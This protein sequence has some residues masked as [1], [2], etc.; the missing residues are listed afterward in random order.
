[1]RRSL[2]ALAMI[3]GCGARTGLVVEPDVCPDPIAPP[4]DFVLIGDRIAVRDSAGLAS[5]A[6]DGSD[7]RLLARAH[8]FRANLAT[9]GNE[10]YWADEIDTKCTVH[11]TTLTGVTRDVR[12]LDCTD[13][14]T[15]VASPVSFIAVDEREVWLIVGGCS[16]FCRSS[17]RRVEHADKRAPTTWRRAPLEVAD[18]WVL[19]AL[20]GDQAFFL[21]DGTRSLVSLDPSTDI[22]RTVRDPFFEGRLRDLGPAFLGANEKLYLREFVVH[23]DVRY[24]AI[25]ERTTT[26]QFSRE[27]T[28]ATLL[29]S[30]AYDFFAT[31]R[32]LVTVEIHNRDVLS[33]VVRW[34]GFD[35]S[36]R[37]VGRCRGRSGVAAWCIRSSRTPRSRLS[38]R[39]TASAG[40][41]FD[42]VPRAA[43]QEKEGLGTRATLYPVAGEDDHR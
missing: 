33:R 20:A 12:T 21:A 34:T 13:T 7:R 10:I 29:D 15:L 8:E 32:G 43:S 18:E 22:V 6:K 5:I 16:D 9:D 27:L 17:G 38:H 11:A 4:S 37:I 30:V 2:L 41:H 31:E 26:G 39:T 25:I 19:I 23:D 1:V 36:T 3:L 35:G 14:W 42:Q 40:F 24:R 28:R